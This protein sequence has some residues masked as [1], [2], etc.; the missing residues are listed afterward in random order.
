MFHNNSNVGSNDVGYV[1]AGNRKNKGGSIGGKYNAGQG[2]KQ[3]YQ[4]NFT[5]QVKFTYQKKVPKDN[6]SNAGQNEK[7]SRLHRNNNSGSSIHEKAWK[8]SKENVDEL[9]RSA[10]KYAVLSG[11]DNEELEMDP[12]RKNRLVVDEFV[13][14]K[15]QPSKGEVMSDEGDV[16]ENLNQ[17]VNSI[18]ADEV[19]VSGGGDLSV[20][21]F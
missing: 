17:A 4:R 1:E 14:K 20:Y 12:Y 16:L 19:L 10:N 3:P 13:K 11:E 6:I 18:I 7:N 21:G 2:N 15:L 5:T 9:K 8:I